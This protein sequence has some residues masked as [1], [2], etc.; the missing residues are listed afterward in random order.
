MNLNIMLLI[1]SLPSGSPG[2][3]APF[4]WFVHSSELLLPRVPKN[5]SAQYASMKDAVS[6]EKT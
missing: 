2:T 1:R 4:G 6:F 5:T 3:S